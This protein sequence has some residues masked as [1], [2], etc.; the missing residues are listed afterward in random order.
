[1]T[2]IPEIFHRLLEDDEYLPKN[3]KRN[4]AGCYV[5]EAPN[6]FP[7]HVYW[8][9]VNQLSWLVLYLPYLIFGLALSMILL[10]R[11]LTRFF[12]TG[13][14]IEKFYNL[15][16]KQSIKEGV[17]CSTLYTRE[18][19]LACQ[20]ILYDFRDSNI[21][22]RAYMC[23]TLGKLL[24]AAAV[25]AWSFAS[26]LRV[27]QSFK[28]N[29]NSRMQGYMH[30]CTIPAN[31][32]NEI[33]F[34]LVNGLMM[35]ILIS[36]FGT[37]VWYVRIYMPDHCYGMVANTKLSRLLNK[38]Q[39]DMKPF[40]S[41]INSIYFKSTD[42]RLLLNILT[43]TKGLW[44]SLRILSLFDSSFRQIFKPQL[45]KVSSTVPSRGRKNI[46]LK[47]R[48]P[49]GALLASLSLDQGQM[50]YVS[51]VD[52]PGETDDFYMFPACDALS[53]EYRLDS[54][55]NNNQPSKDIVDKSEISGYGSDSNFESESSSRNSSPKNS[56][57][58]GSHKNSFSSSS[59][60][61]SFSS[62]SSHKDP[63]A[64]IHVVES[65]HSGKDRKNMIERLLCSDG[66]NSNG[67]AT[68]PYNAVFK[69][70]K[71]GTDYKISISFLLAG[72]CL[73][74]ANFTVAADSRK[75]SSS[76]SSYGSES[77]KVSDISGITSDTSLTAELM[78]IE[79]EEDDEYDEDDIVQ[80]ISSHSHLEDIIAGFIH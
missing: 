30:Q 2:E 16:V 17:N 22:Y 18:N 8:N 19:R 66:S 32:L 23:Q 73:G 5:K 43:E 4:S 28:S 11:L 45:E 63:D 9:S 77:R 33:I 10:E 1:M 35:L 48:E 42:M 44:A 56:I 54:E 14:R 40:P 68:S 70:L 38:C 7:F 26:P 3:L 64:D 29:F 62:S 71:T 78:E 76:S 75:T 57:S 51:E 6:H 67:S 50:M 34:E 65:L 80:K 24:I 31:D 58:N 49:Y 39:Q 69:N 74:V 41:T 59:S 25:V 15:L 21:H 79:E 55:E 20:Q 47:W 53:C 27:R 12:W 13:Q 60:K 36:S 46:N 61:S 72:N 52:P 37:L